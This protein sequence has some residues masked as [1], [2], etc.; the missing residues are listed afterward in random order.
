MLSDARAPGPGPGRAA[1]AAVTNLKACLGRTSGIRV[2]LQAQAQSHWSLVSFKF[3][4]PWQRAE[5]G[6]ELI[7]CF[8]QGPVAAWPAGGA[9][10][11]VRALAPAAALAGH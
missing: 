10:R 5:S 9:R 3:I 7:A 4:Y 2:G 1:A 6:R 8:P 11:T